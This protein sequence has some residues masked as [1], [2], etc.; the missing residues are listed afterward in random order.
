MC[1]CNE[2]INVQILNI[3]QFSDSDWINMVRFS[4]LTD[5]N[6]QPKLHK[7]RKKHFVNMSKMAECVDQIKGRN[8][9][10]SS[11]DKWKAIIIDVRL[12]CNIL[13]RPNI[14]YRLHQ[15]IKRLINLSVMHV[16]EIKQGRL[17][18]SVKQDSF[19]LKCFQ[20]A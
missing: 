18:A 20:S 3:K 1:V 2:K 7:E 14:V 6:S 16:K 4:I 17:R 19:V 5:L 9:S 11:L 10:I 12:W 13:C 15:S 8:F